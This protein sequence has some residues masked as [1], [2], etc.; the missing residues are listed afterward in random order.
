MSN[1]EFAGSLFRNA[2]EM[3]AAIAREYLSAGG[4]NNVADQ[5]E[6]LTRTAAELADSAICDWELSVTAGFDRAAL[7]AAFRSLGAQ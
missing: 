4:L 3:H 2:A 5:A 1:F 6:V 7:V